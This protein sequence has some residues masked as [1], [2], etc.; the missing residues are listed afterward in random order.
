MQLSGI[1]VA[2]ATALRPDCS[3]DV[4][5]TAALAEDL[6]DRGVH[7][8]VVNGSTAEFATLSGDERRRIAEAVIA[9]ANGRV[10]VRVQVGAMSTAEAVAHT[11]HARDAGAAGV[12]LVSPYYEP[13]EE[14]EV[15][16][17]VRAVAG[18]GV[19]VMIYNNPA[20]TGRSLAPE[21]IARLSELDDVRY[22]KDT[23]GDVRR[24]FAI[25]E[26]CGGRIQILNGQDSAALLGFLAGTRAMVWGA[27]N[28]VPEACVRLW[29]LTVADPQ[30]DAARTLWAAMFPLVA[31]LERYGYTAGV[32][33]ATKLRG[34]DVGPPC[35]PTL[36]L[37]PERVEQLQALLTRLET[38]LAGI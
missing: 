22:I 25:A 8:I 7:G 3:L 12:M 10:P 5:A 36:P 33:A 6:I 28:A 15:E 19:P 16:A 32:K 23:T 17:Y 26:L 37:E 4:D 13:L 9:V 31:F 18:V 35:H 2:L 14:R 11:E 34:I 20:S 1:H 24:I 27:A 29:E 30:L 38:T 21:F